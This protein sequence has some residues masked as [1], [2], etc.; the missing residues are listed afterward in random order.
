[1]NYGNGAKTRHLKIDYSKPIFKDIAIKNGMKVCT[2]V[3]QINSSGEI[4][5]RFSSIKEAERY[6]RVKKSHICECCKGKRK[7]SNGFAWRYERNDDLSD[8]QY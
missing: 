3:L 2:P 1:M 6:L 8:C 7:T 5:N 4:M